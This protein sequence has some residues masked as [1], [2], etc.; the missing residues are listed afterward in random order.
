MAAIT[1]C[2]YGGEHFFG[3]SCAAPN[4][5]A[6]AALLRQADYSLTPNQI[7]NHLER[8]AIDM[9]V[10]GFDYFTGYGFVNGY[11]AVAEVMSKSRKSSKSRRGRN[12]KSAKKGK[13]S[14]RGGA[15]VDA[16]SYCEYTDV[17]HFDGLF[18]Y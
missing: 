4:V 15:G 7:Y 11:R 16:L 3:T 5:A 2:R 18:G 13:K 6:V 12:L 17:I 1:I 10:T 14:K 9:N 8:T